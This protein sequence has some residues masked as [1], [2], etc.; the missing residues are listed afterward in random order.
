VSSER[1]AIVGSRDYPDLPAV[2][3][4]VRSLPQDTVIVSG[5][6]EGVDTAAKWAAEKRKMEWR[7]YRPSQL[8][9]PDRKPGKE[10]GIL[11]VERRGVPY[12]LPDRF[13]SFAQAAYFRNGLIVA[14]ADSVEAFWTGSSGTRNTIELARKAGKLG[15]VHRPARIPSR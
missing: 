12:Y 6:A 2:R 5:G 8:S 3:A 15:E 9:I 1:V 4:F 14:D 11:V 10:W 13:E 7:M